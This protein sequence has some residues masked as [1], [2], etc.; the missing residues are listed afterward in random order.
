M[1]AG[2]KGADATVDA[3]RRQRREQTAAARWRRVET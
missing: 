3:I 1:R 2:S